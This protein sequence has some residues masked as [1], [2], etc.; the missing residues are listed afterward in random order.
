MHL[1]NFFT[2]WLISILQ[3]H[4]FLNSD[5]LELSRSPIYIPID[6]FLPLTWEIYFKNEFTLWKE[7]QA[8]FNYNFLMI[9]IFL[10]ST[11]LLILFLL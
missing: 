6:R 11:F 8:L 2:I 4:F 3:L 10:F 1:I 9:P 7:L 5:S